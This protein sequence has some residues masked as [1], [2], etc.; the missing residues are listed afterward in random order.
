VGIRV[1]A[2]TE[3]GSALLARMSFD[4]DNPAD[5]CRS[6]TEKREG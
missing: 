5:W 6:T 3:S 1:V 2:R 4:K